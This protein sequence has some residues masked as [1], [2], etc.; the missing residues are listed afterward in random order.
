[1][2]LII[3]V[4]VILAL[5]LGALAF[6]A[7]MIS[8]REVTHT[9]G[10]QIQAMALAESGI[11][12]VR[13]FLSEQ[14]EAGSA[15]STWYDNAELFQGILVIDDDMPRDRG[16]FAIVSPPAQGGGTSL[17][18]GLECES[19]KINVNT[20]LAAG[21][22]AVAA[23]NRLMALP[24]MTEEIADCILDWLDADDEPREF[25]AEAEYYE[26]LDSPY[27][28]ANGPIGCL[29]ELLFVRGVTPAL[30]F[31]ADRNRNG[32]IDPEESESATSATTSD[33][34]AAGA[35]SDSP[36]AGWSAYLT[37]FSR[38]SICQE[39]GQPK[40]NVNQDDAQALYESLEEAFGS[41][42][43]TFI[44]GYRQQEQLL[45]DGTSASSGTNQN[46]QDGQGGQQ[47]GQGGQQGGQ[48]GQQG[49]QGGQ[50][51]GQDQQGGQG[52]Q[53]GNQGGQQGNQGG[54]G[55]GSSGGDSSGD[56]AAKEEVQ[57]VET[58]DGSLDLTKPLKQKL[59]T[60]L[61]LVGARAKIQYKGET[62]K[63]V[64]VAP[65][66]PNEPDKMREYL[67]Q[68]MAAATTDDAKTA[69]GRVNV[70]LA[71]AEVLASVPGLDATL[72]DEIAAQRPADPASLAD[73]QRNPTWL[74]VDGLVELEQ[75][76][77][78][79]PYL[80]TGG[81]V[82]QVQSVGFFD[83]GGPLVRLQAVLD[84]TESPPRVLSLRNLTPL[85][86]GFDPLELGAQP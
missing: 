29:E 81:S 26:A 48:G 3:V 63:W 21:D 45:T 30:L 41:Q 38:E 49:N 64:I 79:L 1:M 35:T 61:D 53:Q 59:N 80:T 7:L 84:A 12:S 5:C 40:I 43:A 77:T 82:Y 67:P 85:G 44:V 86:R 28:P 74:L 24:D 32:A 83:E 23:R 69:D 60:L 17:R 31:G 78:L 2:V 52:G 65:Q 46:G 57:E 55:G 4:V 50:Q 16:R 39:D 36:G 73:Y 75:M 15:D 56:G 11:E 58:A 34:S 54:S 20:L 76:K 9:T 6:S 19:A 70:N 10:R 18:F 14:P 47:G 51:G 62:T 33:A 42:W 13:Q 25:G 27:R 71:P 37:L 8:E 22:D 72:A 66:F 68:L